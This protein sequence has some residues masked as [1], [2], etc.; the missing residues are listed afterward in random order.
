VNHAAT[1]QIS[2]NGGLFLATAD[3]AVVGDDAVASS[4]ASS[5]AT[6]SIN[7][8][9]T[10]PDLWQQRSREE[11]Q[12][13][14]LTGRGLIVG[15]LGALTGGAFLGMFFFVVCFVRFLVGCSSSSDE[16]FMGFLARP[17]TRRR[18]IGNS[19]SESV[20]PREMLL[21][22]VTMRS[23]G[24]GLLFSAIVELIRTKN[25]RESDQRHKG[26]QKE[27]PMR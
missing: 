23:M 13:Q 14:G 15:I 19:S 10:T 26:C 24:G 2:G 12:Y 17:L 16:S 1:L 22:L 11:P 3:I 4:E 25:D 18:E 27:K 8:L 21:P 9:R 6:F 5:F 20:F 7:L